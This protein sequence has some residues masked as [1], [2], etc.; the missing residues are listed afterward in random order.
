MQKFIISFL[1]ILFSLATFG[2]KASWITVENDS[3]NNTNTWLAFQKDLTLKSRPNHFRIRIACDTKYWLWING[4]MVVFEGQLKRG[5]APGQSYYDELDL[6]N[7]LKK[8]KN[9][10]SV[11]VWYFGKSGFSHE[12]SGK[13]GLYIDSN[14]DLLNTNSSWLSRIHPAYSTAKGVAPNFRLAE[15]NICYDARKAIDG[16]QM[17]DAKN[18]G[19]KASV[20]IG[21]WESEPWGQMTVRPIPMFKDYG[22][23]TIPFN[24]HL[25]KE[26][27][28]LI[29]ELPGNLQITP[30]IEINDNQGGHLIDIWT[31]HTHAASTWNVRAQYITKKGSQ[32][33]ES[34]GWMNGEKI[35][36]YL[37]KGTEV[38]SIGYRQTGYDT[39]VEGT[40]NCDNEFINRY[41]KKA[42]NT[43]YVNMRDNYFDCPDRERAQW[44]GD[45]VILTSQA[46]YT[47]SL[48]S[49][50]LMRKGMLELAA[51][52]MPNGILHA[53]VPGNYKEELPGQ[54][55]ASVGLYGFWNYYMN[56][57][58]SATIRRVYPA[59]KRYLERFPLD[60]TNLTAEYQATW[61]WGDWGE[62]RD[63]RLIF[64]GWHYM[65]LDAMSRMADILGKTSDAEQY[66]STMKRLKQ[67]F[68]QCWTGFSYRH[69]QYMGATDDRVQALAVLA[70][71]ADSSKYDAITKVLKT[72][73]YSSPYMEK[74]VMEALFKM[75]QGEYGMQRFQK[76]FTAMVND[77]D[78][79][80]LYELWNARKNDYRGGSSNHAWSGGGLT[81]I[82]Q[83][84]MGAEVLEPQWR[85]FKIDPQYVVLNKAQLSFPTM[86][87]TISTSFKKEDNA[88]QIY[89]GVPVKSK[90]LVYIPT[91]DIEKI[92]INGKQIKANNIVT[93]TQYIQKN[94]TA[95]WLNRGSHKIVVSY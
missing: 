6:G 37:P 5:P 23:K 60:D 72:Q 76:Q 91:T 51:W 43:L 50:D 17:A 36:L 74:Y 95:V 24:I 20:E 28:T 94:K 13:A 47:L 22:I 8:G 70:G 11:L 19:F 93:E 15:S 29:A 67:G 59:V 55:L 26:R 42:L 52:Q 65:A 53:P 78:V 79:P 40:F 57:G 27:D 46:F 56:T 34:F 9:R 7:N 71:I 45:E 92:T 61:V 4:E 85:T 88:L 54:M 73:Q 84:L 77:Q 25:G 63:I 32:K 31:N 41:W 62:N 30:V 80:T 48:S 12:N 64:A 3:A 39:R 21:S 82:A 33:Y 89:V 10:I 14:N 68:N 86:S 2:A 81:V 18:Y 66:H 87:G 69:P 1:L 44:W 49:I 58:D 75:G 38:K 16:W 35:I 83:K 90:A